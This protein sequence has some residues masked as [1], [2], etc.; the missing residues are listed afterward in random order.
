M[1]KLPCIA[2]VL[3]L[4]LYMFCCPSYKACGS[5]KYDNGRTVCVP[6]TSHCPIT[7]AE[8]APSLP[9]GYSG[10]INYTFTTDDASY[11]WYL[12]TEEEGEMPINGIDFVLYSSSDGNRGQCFE[13]GESHERYGNAGDSYDYINNYPSKCTRVDERWIVLDYQSEEDYLYQNFESESVC[14][15]DA[16]GYDYV[17]TGTQ[18]SSTPFS[19]Q[20]CMM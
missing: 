1:C 9:S 18:C 2:P 20:D 8:V 11:T 14:E 19:D 4:S 17:S 10:S 3:T 12:R 15:E 5:S 6:T 7:G 16:D 13:G